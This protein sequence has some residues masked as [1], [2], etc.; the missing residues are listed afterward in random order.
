[1][2]LIQKIFDDIKGQK[3]LSDFAIAKKIRG[4]RG[5]AIADAIILEPSVAGIGVDLKK[6]LG[7]FFASP[8]DK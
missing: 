8:R 2:E 6:L 5:R 4:G 7:H 1:M 3:D